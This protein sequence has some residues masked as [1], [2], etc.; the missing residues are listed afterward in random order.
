MFCYQGIMHKINN[1]HKRP[2]RLLFENYK[3]DFQNLLRSSGDISIHQ[4]CKN[5]L[6]TEA[7]ENIHGLSPEIKNKVFSTRSNIYN[8]RQFNIFQT[9]IPTSNRYGLNSILY[10]TNQL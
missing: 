10:K 8:T 4:R 5:S 7:Y 9:H 1:I 6:L 3:Y 2:F